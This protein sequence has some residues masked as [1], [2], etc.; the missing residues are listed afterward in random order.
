MVTD[1]AAVSTAMAAAIN[2]LGK[3]PGM[4]ARLPTLPRGRATVTGITTRVRSKAVGCEL[5]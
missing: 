4:A 3:R 5:R 2:L 1:T